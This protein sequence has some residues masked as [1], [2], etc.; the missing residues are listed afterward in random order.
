[1]QDNLPKVPGGREPLP[2]GV[3]WLLLTGE[4][5]TKEDFNDFCS[6]LRERA[7]ITP[8]HLKFLLNL[9]KSLHP[10]TQLSQGLLYLQKDSHFAKA[11]REGIHKTRY[12]EPVLEDSLDLVAKI[13]TIAAVIYRNSFGVSTSPLH[14]LKFIGWFGHRT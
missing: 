3:F 12:W 9:P 14:L 4:I 8:D 10:M 6:D 1:L 5:P 11:Y 7:D 13:P 2:E